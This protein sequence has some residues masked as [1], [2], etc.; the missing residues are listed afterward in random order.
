[1][2]SSSH[3]IDAEDTVPPGGES[4][5]ETARANPTL[6]ALSDVKES[7]LRFASN[8]AEG[9]SPDARNSKEPYSMPHRKGEV[10]QKSMPLVIPPSL[11]AKPKDNTSTVLQQRIKRILNAL[12]NGNIESSAN[13]IL[14]C[15]HEF[16]FE[17]SSQKAAMLS[18]LI[19]DR[20]KREVFSSDIY[21]RLCDKLCDVASQQP[22]SDADETDLAAMLRMRLLAL[23]RRELEQAET[24]QMAALAAS[25]SRVIEATKTAGGDLEPKTD[26]AIR[27]EGYWAEQAAKRGRLVV[28]RF[29]GELYIAGII[30]TAFVYASIRQLVVA[31]TSAD[32]ETDEESVEWLSQWLKIVAWKLERDPKAGPLLGKW[33]EDLTAFVKSKRP[34]SRIRFM[35]WVSSMARRDWS[36]I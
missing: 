33:I 13:R 36:V 12:T 26:K 20:A 10:Y 5:V 34:K 22:P 17:T 9:C 6:R 7:D 27:Y 30:S 29:I 4:P 11:P 28:V 15:V 2:K 32:E 35:I 21:A 25:R 23:C 16:P 18:R 24:Q 8:S 14:K 19:F 3:S 31:I 1:V